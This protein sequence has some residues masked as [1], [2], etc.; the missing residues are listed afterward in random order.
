MKRFSTKD[1]ARILGVT[2][3]QIRTYA[4]LGEIVP[5]RGP[6][7]RL[8]FEFTHLVLLR[9]TKG[10]LEAGVPARRLRRVWTSLKR[11]LEKELP[12][13]SITVFADGERAVAWDGTAAWRPDSGQF[14]LNFDVAEVA[15]RA[16]KEDLEPATIV[17]AE[18]DEQEFAQ[19]AAPERSLGT[20]VAPEEASFTAE[21]WFQLGCELEGESILEARQAYVQT[22]ALDPDFGD[23]HLNLGRLEHE[24]GELGKAEAHYREA[25]RCSPNDA[26]YHFNLGVLLED[27]ERPDEAVF[28]YRRVVAADPFHADAHY[29]LGLLLET[30]GRRSD[31]MRHLMIARRLY[32]GAGHSAE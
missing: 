17:F 7:G 3:D 9:T 31:A 11:Q 22:I 21:Q 4:R 12:L 19:G 16:E 14:L 8:E 10:L 25:V 23:A 26:T 24:A 5:L 18:G 28:A 13:T 32:A 15:E 27:R 20:L 29:N 1:A 6:G 30:M 2:E